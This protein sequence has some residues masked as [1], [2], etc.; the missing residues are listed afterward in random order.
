MGAGE[1]NL[2]RGFAPIAGQ[3]ARVLILGSMPGVASLQKQQYYAHPQNSFWPILGALCGATPDLPYD[4]R[5]QILERSRIAVWDVLQACQRIGSLDTAIQPKSVRIND[6]CSFL[7]EQ[8]DLRLIAFNGTTAQTLW[9]K[10]VETA[11]PERLRT[12]ATRL[13]PSTS[14]AHAT[15]NRAAKLERWRV[16]LQALE[17]KSEG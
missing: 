7:T 11:L 14:P 5:V 9:Q 15:L 10:H 3:Q 6:F 12:I 16:I 13:L 2:L 17:A 8:T 1:D 4:T